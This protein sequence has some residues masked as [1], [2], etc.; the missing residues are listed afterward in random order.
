VETVIDSSILIEHL[1]ANGTKNL[2]FHRA[3]ADAL[4]PIVE[5]LE[6]SAVILPESKG[7]RRKSG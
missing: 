5:G 6:K 3:A 7:R 2:L 1:R 4:R